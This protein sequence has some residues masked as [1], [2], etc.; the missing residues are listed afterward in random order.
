MFFIKII[1]L[2]YVWITEILAGDNQKSAKEV[3]HGKCLATRFIL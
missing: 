1:N 2:T 3:S